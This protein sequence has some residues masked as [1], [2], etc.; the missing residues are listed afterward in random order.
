M[1]GRGKTHSAKSP[2]RVG[3]CDVGKSWTDTLSNTDLHQLKQQ[4]KGANKSYS[5][6]YY[7][8]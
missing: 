1:S 8:L 2:S 5:L 3:E 7:I 4:C 6:M